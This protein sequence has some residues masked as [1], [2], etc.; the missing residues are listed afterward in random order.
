MILPRIK[1]LLFQVEFKFKTNLVIN[2]I[3]SFLTELAG[4]Y[5]GMHLRIKT[6]AIYN[7]W[8]ILS[9]IFYTYFFLTKIKDPRKRKY[10][11]LGVIGYL[12]FTLV[13][14]I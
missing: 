14:V 7:S 9:Y 11:K 13:N 6:F 8:N 2:L 12:A 5:I 4:M 3:Y 1:L 10:L